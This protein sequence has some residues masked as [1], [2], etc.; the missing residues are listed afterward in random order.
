[1]GTINAFFD[2]DNIVFVH[3]DGAT[4]NFYYNGI[5]MTSEEEK[6]LPFSETKWYSTYIK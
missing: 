6:N 3:G 2:K 1:M 4:R 5:K